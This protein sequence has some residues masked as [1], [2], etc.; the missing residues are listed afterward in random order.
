MTLQKRFAG[1]TVG[2]I[3][4]W[5]LAGC[6]HV[7][8]VADGGEPRISTAFGILRIEMPDRGGLLAA[9][10]EGIG[11][12]PSITGLALGWTRSNAVYLDPERD[13]RIV[14]LVDDRARLERHAALLAD[15][16]A[17]HSDLCIPGGRP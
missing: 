16:K 8:I 1:T 7:S 2:V 11:V 5:G 3:A 14:L 4:A 10:V 9:S 12:V 17:R 6:T 15:L 13:C